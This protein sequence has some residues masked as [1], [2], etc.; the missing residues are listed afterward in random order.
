[1][2]LMTSVTLSK[3]CLLDFIVIKN[4][5]AHSIFSDHLK[6]EVTGPIMLAQATSLSSIRWF[7]IFSASCLLDVVASIIIK[8]AFTLQTRICSDIFGL[9][10]VCIV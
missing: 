1:M 9:K 2:V 6:I 4:S 10:R 3:R 8:L 5:S 7:A